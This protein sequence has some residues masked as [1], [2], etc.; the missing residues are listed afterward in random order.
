MKVRLLL[1]LV[2]L[3]IGFTVPTLA[4][5]GNTPDPQLRQVV[6]A[7]TQK[8]TEAWNNSDP[9]TLAA[10]YTEDAVQVT[11]TDPIYGWDD[12]GWM[13]SSTLTL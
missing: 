8:L 3:A 9:T 7:L 10:L 13:S 5:Q 2:A 4:Q 1:A 12:R 11:D 6:D